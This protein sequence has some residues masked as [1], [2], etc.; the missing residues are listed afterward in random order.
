MER[1]FVESMV[2]VH[3][4]EIGSEEE[5]RRTEVGG[6]EL[7]LEDAQPGASW[8]GQPTDGPL[9]NPAC[10]CG[11]VGVCIFK[12]LHQYTKNQLRNQVCWICRT[13]NHRSHF[14]LKGLNNLYKILHSLLLPHT[15]KKCYHEQTVSSSRL[16]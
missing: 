9:C 15:H 8:K 16:G 6:V 4:Q 11:R 7:L 10:V 13:R 5:R 14:C 2:W 1:Q 12:H 3:C